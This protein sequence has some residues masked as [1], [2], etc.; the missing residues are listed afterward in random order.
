VRPRAYGIYSYRIAD[1]RAFF[2]NVSGTR[3]LYRVE[4]LEDQLRNTI[5]ARLTDVVAP[6]EVAFLDMAA[7]QAGDLGRY[8]QFEAAQSLETAAANTG[9]AAGVGVGLG[10]GV[11]DDPSDLSCPVCSVPLAHAILGEHQILYCTRCRGSLIP[12]PV[13]VLMLRDLRAERAGTSAIPHPPDP[14]ELRRRI[15]CPQCHRAMDI[16]YY[17]GPGNIVIDDCAPCELNW[18]DAG[19]LMVIV[20]A[21]DHASIR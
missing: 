7:H 2:T 4:D 11:L 18:L 6:S 3:E 8:T 19:E 17:A 16:H 20:R 12:A 21:P 15:P 9:G 13:F 14:K 10:A 1:P 5:V